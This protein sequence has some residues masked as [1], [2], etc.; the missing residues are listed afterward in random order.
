MV[1]RVRDSIRCTRCFL[2]EMKI[3]VKSIELNQQAETYIQK[4]FNRLER[5][6]NA[7]SDAKL[8]VSKTS[9]RSQGDRVVA[10]MTLSTKGFTLRGQESGL[11][12]YAAID[13]VTDV[14]DRQIRRFKTRYYRTSRGRKSARA[15]SIRENI[16]MASVDETNPDDTDVLDFGS[17][18]RT[19]RF[20]MEPLALDDAI[21]EMELLN[22]SFFLFFNSETKEFNVLYRR[23]DGNYGVIEP[24]LA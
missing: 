15:E 12:L 24:E 21:T 22:H 7:I 18:V 3:I 23:K 16:E 14:M 6:L 19:K 1:L 4:K 20:V 13:A 11:N 2:V 9:T 17:V 8:E 5:H 10:Q